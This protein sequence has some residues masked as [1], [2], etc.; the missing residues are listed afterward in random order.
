M[1][2]LRQLSPVTQKWHQLIF[3]FN[4]FNPCCTFGKYGNLLGRGCL[5]TF[6]SCLYFHLKHLAVMCYKHLVQRSPTG[7]SVASRGLLRY[8]RGSVTLFGWLGYFLYFQ[9]FDDDKFVYAWQWHRWAMFVQNKMPTRL[10]WML[11]CH[12]IN[13]QIVLIL[14]KVSVDRHIYEWQWQS[15]PTHC[16]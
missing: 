9:I 13:W 4:C 15:C 16:T 2:M 14:T 6:S 3:V 12:T 5:N 8:C 1:L 10:A 7:G 11:E